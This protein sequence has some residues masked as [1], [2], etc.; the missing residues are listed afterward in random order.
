MSLQLKNRLNYL[1]ATQSE[2]L[3]QKADKT[4]T[5][6]RTAIDSKIDNLVNNAP[7]A[8]NTLNELAQAL[9]ADANFSSTVINSIATKA[10]LNNPTCTGTVGGLS[11]AMVG[12]ANVDDTSDSAKPISTATQTALN[13]KA[14]LNNPTFTGTVRGDA[15]V[16]TAP[17]FLIAIWAKLRARVLLVAL[18]L[19]ARVLPRSF[20]NARSSLKSLEFRPRQDLGNGIFTLLA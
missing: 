6:S 10:P 16:V 18:H 7:T 17:I 13:L 3:D 5:Y 8:L 1:E 12:L 19:Y 2:L 4:F 20:E 15:T 14:P 9:G 11:K